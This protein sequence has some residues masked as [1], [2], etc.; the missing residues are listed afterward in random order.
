MQTVRLWYEKRDLLR[1]IS[2][3]DTMR[4]FT[5]AIVRAEIPIWYTEGF[6]PHPY[7]NFISPVSLG[8]E[9][10]CEP[11]D[12]R[13]VGEM[14]FEE[15]KEKINS[16]LPDDIKIVNITELVMKPA[17][18]S[19]ARYRIKISDTD[20]EKLVTSLT[21]GALVCTKKTKKGQERIIDVSANIKVL[22]FS[23]DE[24]SLDIDIVLPCGQE[25]NINPI[26][27]NDSLKAHSGLEFFPEN[28]LRVDLY[29]NKMEQFL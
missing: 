23:I 3:L 1:F 21:S 29:N 9:C 10:A 5:R 17:E 19:F 14:S 7:I 15:I 8:V 12:I 28:I 26:N 27:F 16:V 2:H 6:N 22:N 13:L 24:N 4:C 11:F 18:L 20:I 25:L